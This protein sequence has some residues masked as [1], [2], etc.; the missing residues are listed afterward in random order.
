[1]G[2]LRGPRRVRLS[3]SQWIASA[4]RAPFSPKRATL[5]GSPQ[6][7]RLD[8]FLTAAEALWR[9]LWRALLTKARSSVLYARYSQLP[10]LHH[11]RARMR[12]VGR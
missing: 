12:I 10:M 2:S 1:V 3:H 5:S 7:P 4:T 9:L 6:P 8:Q 11:A